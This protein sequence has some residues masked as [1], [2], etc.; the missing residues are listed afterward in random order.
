MKHLIN[1]YCLYNIWANQR[2]VEWLK[3]LD[4]TILQKTTKSSFDTI[5][6]TLQHM[7]RTQ[8]FWT[9][10]VNEEN[11][12]GFNWKVRDEHVSVIINELIES[13]HDMRNC[14]SNFSE[15]DLQKKLKLDMPWAKNEC[16]RYEYIIHVI[17]HS[18][19][20]RGQIVTMARTLGVNNGIPATDYNIFNCR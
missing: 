19:F 18:T 5:D 2:L 3:S 14:F 1:N 17:N 13:S 15:T 8:I 20:H 10:F 4:H 6:H 16:S 12:S 9:R 11:I 7:L